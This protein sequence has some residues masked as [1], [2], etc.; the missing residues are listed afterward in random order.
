MKETHSRENG[1]CECEY[2]CVR[3]GIDEGALREG[4]YFIL[5]FIHS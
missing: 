5:M 4:N 1:T 2:M 3:D